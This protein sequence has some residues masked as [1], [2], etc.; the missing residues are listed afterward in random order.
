MSEVEQNTD[1]GDQTSTQPIIEKAS[2]DTTKKE[3]KMIPQSTVDKL[4]GD[5]RF[6]AYEKG[7][8]DAEATF[9]SNSQSTSILDEQNHP[10]FSKDELE[11]MV[12][13]T[14]TRLAQEKADQEIANR[15]VLEIGTKLDDAKK[16]YDKDDFEKTIENLNLRSNTNIIEL[17]YGIENSGDLLYH[18]GQNPAKFGSILA[19]SVASPVL[20]RKEMSRLALS[21]KKQEDNNS[22]NTVR[23][24]LSQVKTSTVGAGNG[25]KSI[26]DLRRDPAFRG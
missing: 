1:I 16:N 19:L 15:M 22:V 11:K 7:K 21:L 3:E 18:L 24:P 17:S 20:A 26:R 8:K 14:A 5:Y 12:E 13:T 6:T 9:N 4:I 25:K 23:E 2:A 10:N